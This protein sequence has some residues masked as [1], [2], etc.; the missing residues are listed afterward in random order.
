MLSGQWQRVR[1]E[2]P[3]GSTKGGF[4]AGAQERHCRKERQRED[5]AGL[6]AASISLHLVLRLLVMGS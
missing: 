1:S 2:R 3:K 4:R 5:G 6:E